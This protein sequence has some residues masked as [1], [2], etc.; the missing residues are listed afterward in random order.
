MGI[1][2]VSLGVKHLERDNMAE[3][4]ATVDTAAFDT[5][6]PASLLDG[7]GIPRKE[8]TLVS[9]ADGREVEWD[10]GQAMLYLDGRSWACPVVFGEDDIYLCGAG[11]LEIFKLMVDPLHQELVP[12]PPRPARPF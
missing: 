7:L 12:I 10:I 4:R 2:E 9:L 8:S 6:L 11:T 1:F 3:V 5:V